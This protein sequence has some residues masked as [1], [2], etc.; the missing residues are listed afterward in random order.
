[1][2][3]IFSKKVFLLSCFVLQTICCFGGEVKLYF[4]DTENKKGLTCVI[5]TER[6][7]LRSLSLKDEANIIKINS[8]PV[9]MKT[10]KTGVTIS[11]DESKR[12]VQRMNQRWE[13]GCPYAVF[14]IALKEG[15]R[16]TFLGLTGFYKE[17]EE[18][19]NRIEIFSRYLEL[20]WNKGYATEARTALLKDYL[21]Y[22]R[23][24]GFVFDPIKA[25]GV[26][27]NEI[28]ATAMI[29]NIGSLRV[30]E[31]SGFVNMNKNIV[32]WNAERAQFLYTF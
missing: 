13:D 23:K 5:T 30:L 1:M 4:R 17:D 25:P 26:Q 9:V 11:E 22:L 28:Y 18:K 16:E 6:L 21:P 31:K 2:R 24:E 15:D 14:T 19:Y 27:V 20:S 7:V 29:N 32:K 10:V 12:S 3:S 8:D